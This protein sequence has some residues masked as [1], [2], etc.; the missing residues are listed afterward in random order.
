MASPSSNNYN[1]EQSVQ[2]QVQPMPQV[3]FVKSDPPAKPASSSVLSTLYTVFH[4]VV[5]IF[6]IYLS[7]QCNKTG[8]NLLSFLAALF[9]PYVYILYIFVT[10][11][12]FCGVKD[13]VNKLV[14]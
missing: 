5:S 6:A 12:D 4:L 1:S 3:V 10:K 14:R 7:F 11:D 2:Q 8:F 13:Q 9:F